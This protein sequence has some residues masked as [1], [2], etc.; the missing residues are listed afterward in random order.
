M[1]LAMPALLA[2]RVVQIPTPYLDV[3]PSPDNAQAALTLT[4]F[5][6]A[7]TAVLCV[8]SLVVAAMAMGLH[9]WLGGRVRWLSCGLVFL[10]MAT[11]M[12]HLSTS[13]H[14]DD[15]YHSSAWLAAAA[16]GLAALHL[17]E[18][19][20]ARRWLAA[21]LVAMLVPLLIQAL[22]Y[23]FV[24]HAATVTQYMQ[25]RQQALLQQGIEPGSAAQR[26]YERRL[27]DSAFTGALSMSNVTGGITAAFTVL[28]LAGFAFAGDATRVRRALR[29]LVVWVGLA[30]VWLTASKGALAACLLGAGVAAILW[31]APRLGLGSWRY[32]LALG[33]AALVPLAMAVVVFRGVVLGPPQTWEGERS[34]LFRWYYWV[35]AWEVFTHARVLPAGVG[36]WLFNHLFPQFKPS[37][38]P[39]DVASTHNVWIDYIITLGLG[40]LAWSAALLLWLGR[41]AVR[42]VQSETLSAAGE[43]AAAVW[44]TRMRVYVLSGLAAVVFGIQFYVQQA[45]MY[46]ITVMLWLVQAGAF[47]A[48]AVW[49]TDAA[50]S[51]HAERALVVGSVAAGLV[52]LVHGQIEMTFFHVGSS[53]IAWLIMGLCGAVAGSENV[54]K[55]TANAAGQGNRP[56]RVCGFVAVL[57]AA[58]AVVV[59]VT[60]ARPMERLQQTMHQAGRLVAQGE[61]HRAIEIMEKQT[62]ATGISGR[63]FERTIMFAMRGSMAQ[64]QWAAQRFGPQSPQTRQWQ[65]RAMQYAE[66]LS[67]HSPLAGMRARAQMLGWFEP[68]NPQGPALWE[69]IVAIRPYNLQDHLAAATAYEQ[70][71]Q[72]DQVR[73]LYRRL[74][75]LDEQLYLDPVQQMPQEQRRQIEARLQASTERKDAT[76]EP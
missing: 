64:A 25:N 24:E 6:P 15:G 50:T 7:Q 22:W 59:A 63:G 23:V 44:P 76:A 45:M 75:W 1:L 18:H 38:L 51:M 11:A 66:I 72:M 13:S 54:G 61:P 57:L 8:V 42:A 71:G 32:A 9:A 68:Q 19:A 33:L 73:E 70:A 48:V 60:W 27:T 2:L 29:W 21:M 4:A 62:A 31:W 17:A 14:F 12:W 52:V 16:I 46:D 28:A 36:V 39:E 10:G 26:A 34:L 56:S 5:G 41:G 43:P 30:V 58:T 55:T 35:G 20:T 69:Q 37:L 40:G 65:R 74:L 53:L 67:R 47:V 49:L 3:M